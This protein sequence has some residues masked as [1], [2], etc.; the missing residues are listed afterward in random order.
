MSGLATPV[1]PSLSL[2]GQCMKIRP[3]GDKQGDNRPGA[4][5]LPR[6]ETTAASAVCR[7]AMQPAPRPK[8]QVSAN[9]HDAN[10]GSRLECI[11]QG[12]VLCRPHLQ[13]TDGQEGSRGVSD[14]P[15]WRET[16]PHARF[17]RVAHAPTPSPDYPAASGPAR[18]RDM[19]RSPCAPWAS[20]ALLNLHAAGR[21]CSHRLSGR[22]KPCR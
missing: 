22:T 20:V 12:G 14:P 21:V 5:C 17:R 19:T 13:R 8:P 15:P 11:D 3:R 6:R 16:R 1:S 10:A 9:E 4:N 2:G 7:C 18:V